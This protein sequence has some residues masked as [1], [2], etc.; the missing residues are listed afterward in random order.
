MLIHVAGAP[1][2][3]EVV[4]PALSSVGLRL[5]PYLGRAALVVRTHNGSPGP[6]MTPAEMDEIARF[7]VVVGSRHQVSVARIGPLSVPT[8]TACPGCVAAHE[9]VG[10]QLHSL[11]PMA[12]PDPVVLQLA[13]AWAA[14]EVAAH[15]AHEQGDPALAPSALTWGHALVFE[16]DA[17]PQAVRLPA[18]PHCGCTWADFMRA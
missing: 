10:E 16:R 9:Q 6:G 13:A 4:A 3:T 5:T 17:L 11:A 1:M 2:L 18:H 8:A 15:V 7:D 14:S 12:L